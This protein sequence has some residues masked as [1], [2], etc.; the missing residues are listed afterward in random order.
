LLNEGVNKGRPLQ[1]RQVVNDTRGHVSELL[2]KAIKRGALDQ[3]MTAT[4]KERVVEFL[5]VTATFLQIFSTRARPVRAIALSR[6]PASTPECRVSR[7]IC[8]CCWTRI[9]GPASCSRT[10]S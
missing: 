4:D 3:E 10:C 1:Q 5:R 2:A 7:S 6:A 8:G 9:S